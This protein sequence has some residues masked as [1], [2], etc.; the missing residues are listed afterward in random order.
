MLSAADYTRHDGLGLAELV[1]RGEV[2]PLELLETALSIAGRLDPQLNAIVTPMHEIARARAAGALTGPFAGLPFLAKDISQEYAGVPV[3]YGSRALRD[4]RFAPAEHA[5]IVV[6]WLRAGVVVFGRTNVPEFGAKGITE[7]QAW[8][9]C[10][11]PWNVARTPGG[12]S[13]GAAA[14]VAAGIVPIAGANDGGGSIRIPAAHCGLFGFKPGR[15]RTPLGPR[16]VER[17]HGAVLD[18]VLTRSVR[19]SAAM[20]DATHGPEVG[21]LFTIAPPER[22]YS[23]ELGRGPGRLTIAYSTRSPIGTKVDAEAIQAVHNA[24]RLLETLGHHVEEAVPDLDGMQLAKDFIT[25]WFATCAATYDDVRRRTGCGPEAFELDTRAM[26]AF[27][28][29]TPANA[30]VEGYLRWNEYARR[31]GEFHQRYDLYL[32]PTLALPPARIGEIRTPHWQQAALRVL[33][34]LRLEGLALKTDIVEQMVQENLKW[35]PFTQ[36][37]NLT[38]TPAMSVP[39]HW[40]ADGLP[41]GVQL[42]A[43]SGG[44]GLLFRVAAQLEQAQPWAQRRPAIHAANI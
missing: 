22:P 34:A 21:A 32:T 13:G 39:L 36:L 9:A 44:E 40:T 19:D 3:S 11:N 33:L 37:A 18:H 43:A 28:R 30:Y 6:R 10:R 20:L 17:M 41:L 14:A 38:G 35:V 2:T 15:G 23:E 12:S 7:P 4:P 5:E 26:A 8:G 42:S 29:A 31:L 27:G 24:A 1:R 16:Y 25:M